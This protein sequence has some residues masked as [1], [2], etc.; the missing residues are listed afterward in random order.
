MM[1]DYSSIADFLSSGKYVDIT[2][3]FERFLVYKYNSLINCKCTGSSMLLKTFAC[4]LD[5]DAD[6]KEMF[7][8]LS[9]GKDETLIRHANS[10][11]V[12]YLDFSDFKAKDFGQAKEYIWHA[13]SEAYKFFFTC[14]E[15]CSGYISDVNDYE[16]A[17]DLIEGQVSDKVLQSS[18]RNL[19]LKLRGYESH[20]TDKRLAVLID[21]MIR[22]ETVA[23]EYGYS[24]E[25]NRFL[26][27]FIVN[28]VYRYCNI[29]LQISD[30]EEECD[31]LFSTDNHLVYRYFCVSYFDMRDRFPE[32]IVPQERQ[33]H[34]D[35]LPYIPKAYDWKTCIADGRMRVSQARREEERRR[36]E[37]IRSEKKRYAQ[38]LSPDIPLLSPNMGIRSK[39]LDK[40]TQRYKELNALMRNV[41]EKFHPEY[42]QN[43]IAAKIAT[44]NRADHICYWLSTKEFRL[45]ENFY[46]PYVNNL[47]ESLPF[48]TYKSHLGI[49]KEFWGIDDSHNATFANI[50]AD[51]LK[52]VSDVADV[53]LENMF[54]NYIMKWNADIY[55]ESDYGSFKT[56]TALSFVVIMDTLDAILSEKELS[57]N[58]LLL[59]DNTKFWHTLADSI[60]WADVNEKWE[61]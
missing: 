16:M 12:L 37:H 36:Q 46:K 52:T 32:M 49:S 6:T 59:S 56:N 8:N 50:I 27:S 14:F 43:N 9:I 60:C 38:K 34:F 28:D 35:I 33:A 48:I 11:R 53:D 29:F 23:E 26:S 1:I 20:Y 17:L 19:L 13:M 40:G 5:E 25:M 54:N 22:F 31:A 58:L 3:C 57:E 15:P 42:S 45:L 61:K 2:Q 18:L 47:V 55:E 21:N 30:Y 51:Y 4:F 24:E 39:S 41:Y 10:Y 44:C 7:Q